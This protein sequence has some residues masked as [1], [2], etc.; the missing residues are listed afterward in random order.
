V[1]RWVVA[2]LAFAGCSFAGA[3]GEPLADAPEG[4]LGPGDV[5]NVLASCLEYRSLGF[6]QS[7]VYPL[8]AAEVDFAAHC[9]METEGGG[10]TLALKIDGTQQT[11]E[12]GPDTGSIWQT[13]DLLNPDSASVDTEEAKLATFT[14]VRLTDIMLVF[15]SSALPGSWPRRATMS[16]DRSIAS[17]RALLAGGTPP[18]ITADVDSWRAMVEGV[19]LQA[20]CEAPGVNHANG[21]FHRQRLGV[22][23]NNE[24]NCDTDDSGVGV[25]FLSTEVNAPAAGAENAV[26]RTTMEVFA[27]L[28]V[29]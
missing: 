28:Y 13:D 4:G 9:D 29:R 1:V 2:A 22:D 23:F 20:S 8:R 10:W 25:G 7:G 21:F 26:D 19:S 5:V 14:A 24:P 15:D 6:D 12:F 3:P 18:V 27:L 11:F 16:L 17:L